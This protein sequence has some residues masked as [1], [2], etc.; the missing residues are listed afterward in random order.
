MSFLFL[1]LLSMVFSVRAGVQP[2]RPCSR[3]NATNCVSSD[4]STLPTN[5]VGSDAGQSA[6][7]TWTVR[8]GLLLESSHATGT[9]TGD[10]CL[11]QLGAIQY[12]PNTKLSDL[13]QIRVKV[14]VNSTSGDSAGI[15]FGDTNGAYF[16]FQLNTDASCAYT[17]AV[18]FRT[19]NTQGVAGAFS[20]VTKLGSQRARS[21]TWYEFRMR[22]LYAD[23]TNG[24]LEVNLVDLTPVPG[25]VVAGPK[26]T[27]DN[28]SLTVGTKIGLWCSSDVGCEF[29]DF[30]MVQDSLRE[31]LTGQLDC[32]ACNLM[33][34]EGSKDWCR[35]CQQDCPPFDRSACVAQ[36]L[37]TSMCMTN[38]YC[39]APATAVSG[40][41]TS[42]T[43]STTGTT[44]TTAPGVT[45][46]AAGGTTTTS[47]S[48]SRQKFAE[49]MAALGAIAAMMI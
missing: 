49:V 34:L 41:E 39:Q 37:C 11:S 18:A 32:Q 8:D 2:W 4:F 24:R 30:V 6:T 13:F 3:L 23:S 48:G 22:I 12:V 38:E 1:L 33:W 10:A 19:A 9:G 20:E 21:G 43:P 27:L 35:C 29:S 47:S 46:S 40:G 36:G 5:G 42:T 14:R 28:P 25:P 26:V 44:S 7:G 45:T 15:V 17:A 16:R 31:L